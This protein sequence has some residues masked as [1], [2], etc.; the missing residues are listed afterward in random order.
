MIPIKLNISGFLSYRQP[1][2]IDFSS[3][4]LACI[5][6]SNGAGKSSILDAITWSLFGQAR[7]R[8]DSVINTRSEIAEVAFSFDYEGNIYR[9]IRSYQRGKSV[10]LEFQIQRKD[11]P[12]QEI[13][14]L[15][16]DQDP[17]SQAVGTW[18]TLSERTLRDTQKS[19]EDTLRLDYETFVNAAFFLQ[20]EADL[21]TQ[22]PPGDRKRILTKILG[23]EIWETYRSRAVEQ[24][25]S[26]EETVLSLDGRLAE[27]NSELLEEE[28]RLTQLTQLE[29][30]LARLTKVRLTQESNLENIKKIVASLDELRKNVDVRFEQLEMD[31]K[32][33]GDLEM[34][35]TSRN[36]DRDKYSQVLLK[37]PEIMKRYD[38]LCKSR[39]SLE[40]LDQIAE[41]FRKH[42]RR[43]EA[44]RLKI[45]SERARLEQELSSLR[46]IE[47]SIQALLASK[48]DN[49][50][51]VKSQIEIISSIEAD[52]EKRKKLDEERALTLE[53]LAYAKGENPQLKK[54]MEDLKSKIEMLTETAGAVCP[55]CGQP[56]SPEERSNLIDEYNTLGKTMGDKYRKNLTLVDEVGEQVAALQDKIDRLADLDGKLLQE[57]DILNKINTQLDHIEEQQR[58]WE[59]EGAPR[60]K[61][62]IKTLE[63]ESFCHEFRE[64]LVKIDAELKEIGY[65]AAEHDKLRRLV[66]ENQNTEEEYFTLERAKAALEPL[67]KEI[68]NIKADIEEQKL[69]VK[70]AQEVYDQAVT[71]YSAHQAQAP[72]LA[73]AQRDF[74]DT[75]E[76]ENKIHLEVGAARQKVMVL[77]DLKIRR[78]SL[79]A[80]RGELTQRIGRYKQLEKAFGKDGVPALLIE[81]ALPQIENKANDILDRL[82]GGTMSVRFITQREYK[83]KSR[84]DLRETL[85]IQISDDM[86]TREYEMFSGGEAFRVNF[87]IRLALSEILAQRAGARLQ[88][89]VIDEGFGSQDEIGRQRLIETINTVKPDFAKILVI[90]H[91]ETLKE[92]FPSRIEVEKTPLGSII[93]VQ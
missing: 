68:E 56:L 19:I 51:K 58:S 35:L 93:N 84:K 80:D 4:D 3:I 17:D 30:E 66:Q 92:A 59:K 39:E 29:E 34:R 71:T 25:K 43:R 13:D 67:D 46:N 87:S 41:R 78:K 82:S 24:R 72:D 47:S 45:E 63:D 77:D 31:K 49:L 61:L 6:G 62:V 76:S 20:G 36:F 73:Q 42:E 44:P 69:V 26:I 5:A 89:L 60:L 12:S 40:N 70:T 32:R 16:M 15:S 74:L 90:T 65:D 14:D 48:P 53:K 1:V 85:D 9:V 8:D 91:I 37:E 64:I 27:I 52:I 21:F 10:K 54:E 83:D 88:T 57:K 75:R 28:E 18:K 2:E 23:L 38:S 7:R 81:S 55:T 79:E 22:Q 50:E 86:G 11:S 33:E